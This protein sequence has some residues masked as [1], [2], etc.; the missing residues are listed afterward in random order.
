MEIHFFV[1]VFIYLLGFH[2]FFVFIFWKIHF[3]CLLKTVRKSGFTFGPGS[4]IMDHL[5][6][7]YFEMILN[8]EFTSPRDRSCA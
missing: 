6:E 8:Q 1:F 7:N 3:F 4:V 2:L 5:Y